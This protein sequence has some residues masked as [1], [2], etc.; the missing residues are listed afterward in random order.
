VASGRHCSV[1]RGWISKDDVT[2]AALG[3]IVGT[4]VLPGVGGALLG[5]FAGSIAQSLLRE[6]S[7]S[8]KRVFV[9]FDFDNDRVLK[10][11]V[12]GQAKNADSPFE[13]VDHSL[14]EAAP[15]R[16]WERKANNAISSADIVLVM[17]GPMT[18]RAQGVLKEIAMARAAGVKVVQ[19][20]GYKEGRYTPVPD[21]GRLYSWSRGNLEKLLA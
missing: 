19:I 9:S 15:E 21:A 10:D 16:N 5:G 7:M 8:K 6:R 1:H 11:F 12:L 2:A 3:A 20:I 18:H 13:V 4:V 14:K 17:V